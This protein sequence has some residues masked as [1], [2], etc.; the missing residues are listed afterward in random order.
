ML[1]LGCLVAG[2]KEQVA[3]TD[4]D[5]AIALFNA[6]ASTHTG[7]TD[8]NQG[9]S[10]K[11]IVELARPKITQGMSLDSWSSFQVLWKLYKDSADLSEAECGPQLVHCCNEDLV[12][13][14]LCMDP[15]VV[16]KPETEQL[17]SIRKLAV[18]PYDRGVRRSKM[19]FEKDQIRQCRQNAAESAARRPP[20]VPKCQSA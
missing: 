2:C 20:K 9:S 13:Q 7:D 4:E 14:L 8:C 15:N 11:K 1:T 12:M 6:H 18:I 10:V 16:D 3:N 5:V 17:D 19:L